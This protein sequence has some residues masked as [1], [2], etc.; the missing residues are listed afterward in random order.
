MMPDNQAVVGCAVCHRAVYEQDVN[1][2]GVCVLCEAAPAA[3]VG[4]STDGQAEIH[5]P[6]GRK[7]RPN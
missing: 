2:E 3:D 4:E 6:V 5:R 7:A 1:A